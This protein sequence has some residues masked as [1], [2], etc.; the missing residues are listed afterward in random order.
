[1]IVTLQALAVTKHWRI[2]FSGFLHPAFISG[3]A[4]NPLACRET[5]ANG[6]QHFNPNTFPYE[7]P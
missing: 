5:P 6:S 3:F 7:R 2:V 4:E 1:M